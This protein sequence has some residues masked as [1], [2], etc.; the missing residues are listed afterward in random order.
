MQKFLSENKNRLTILIGIALF[1]IAIVLSAVI[2]ANSNIYI[3]NLGTSLVQDGNLVNTISTSGDGKVFGKPDM[4]SFSVSISELASTSQQ[5]L[6]NANQKSNEVINRIKNNGVSEDDIQ[7][8]QLN[9]YPE[10]DYLTSGSVLKG[11]RAT[12]SISVD[13]K[14][15]DSTATKVAQIIDSVAQVSNVSIGSI[16]FDIQDKTSLFSK[17]REL[18]YNKAK[19]KAEELSKLSSTKLLEPVSISDAT[20]ETSSP[21]PVNYAAEAATMGGKGSDTSIQ[22]GQLEVSVNLNVVFGIE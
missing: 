13:V 4:A 17:A 2:F 5:A 3:K 16:S 11:Q 19:Q 6:A 22:T 18:A 7:T 10:Y 8:S 9:I 15:I 14:G 21:L 12:I 20:Y 1:S